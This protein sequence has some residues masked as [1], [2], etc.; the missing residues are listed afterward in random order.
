MLFLRFTSIILATLLALSLLV[1]CTNSAQSAGG[2]G[3]STDTGTSGTGTAGSSITA[4]ESDSAGTAKPAN[5]EA[6]IPMDEVT[7][8]AS[9]YPASYDGVEMEV[10]AV[11]ASDGDCLVA[12]NTCY[13]C[14][15]SGRGYYVQD[16]DVLVCQNCGSRF[17]IDTL[18]VNTNA[19]SPVLV[20]DSYR[21]EAT[22]D[23]TISATEMAPVKDLFANWKK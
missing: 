9:F 11:R 16:G 19:C 17:D 21:V 7:T 23:L 18:A 15:D 8:T 14:Y 2:D 6:I 1:G 3:A 10:L 20:F 5:S 4:G 22:G 13:T 12:F